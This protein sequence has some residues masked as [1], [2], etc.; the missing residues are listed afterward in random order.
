[1]SI[2]L[3]LEKY[4][5]WSIDGEDYDTLEW[6][7]AAI[8]K[9]SKAQLEAEALILHNEY[10]LSQLRIA[11][12]KLIA[13]T[14]WWASSDLVMSVSQKQYRQALRDIT[15]KYNSLETVVWPVKP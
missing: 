6:H 13:E 5:G 1:M 2:K 4:E 12:D 8:P 9:P 15:L 10:A 3:A 11:R 14:D 7:N